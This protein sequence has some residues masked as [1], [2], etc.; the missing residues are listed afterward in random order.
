M[1]EFDFVTDLE[2]RDSLQSDHREMGL[3]M[4]SGAWKAVHVLCGS[5]VEAVLIDYL[6]SSDHVSRDK[7]LS[8]D[9]GSALPI[10]REKAV[11]SQRTV[12]LSSA[13]KDYRNLVHPGRT[14][15]LS[16]R[17]DRSSAEVAR[18][19]LRM[20]TQQVESSKRESYGYTA[21]QIASKLCRDSSADSIVPMLLKGVKP[22]E[23]ERL[24]L[25]IL[26]ESYLAARQ[27]ELAQAHVCP[28]LEM[29]FRAAFDQAPEELKRR[30]VG[31]FVSIVSEEGEQV[32]LSY[33]HA[34]VRA[35]DLRYLP[36]ESAELLTQH[37]LGRLAKSVDGSLLRTLKGIGAFV[38]PEQVN[39]LVDPL[40]RAVRGDAS[41]QIGRQARKWL[42]AEY[43]VMPASIDDLVVK[44]VD[45]WIAMY[46][47]RSQQSEVDR[48][49]EL[50]AAFWAIPF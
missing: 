32:V 39:Q 37:L 2:F 22:A 23:I 13:I 33:E 19:V 6:L 35:T 30:V 8:M 50:K 42:E 44:R 45:Q 34:F 43:Q 41:A 7:A 29:C 47:G 5:I 24:L 36:S 15:R 28:A 12:D 21:E 9:L 18:A 17:V 1:A 27:D 3:C 38:K 10:C 40:I 11:I 4:D 31:R 26:P 46:G 14:I 25:K 49:N 16:D 48:L 20:I